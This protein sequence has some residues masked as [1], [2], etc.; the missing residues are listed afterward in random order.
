MGREG[1]GESVSKEVQEQPRKGSN[2]AAVTA[3]AGGDQPAGTADAPLPQAA[4]HLKDASGEAGGRADQGDGNGPSHEPSNERTESSPK[5]AGEASEPGERSEASPRDGEDE[6]KRDAVDGS[7]GQEGGS[8]EVSSDAVTL[9]T[10]SEEVSTKGA[11]EAA[12]KGVSNASPRSDAPPEREDADHLGSGGQGSTPNSAIEAKHA[13]NADESDSANVSSSN[14]SSS[15]R[16]DER[17]DANGHEEAETEGEG[18][19]LAEREDDEADAADE[20]EAKGADVT[21]EGN[22]FNENGEEEEG[23]VEEEG[24]EGGEDGEEGEGGE[25]GEEGEYGAE[26]QLEVLME[27]SARV[28]LENKLLRSE[29]RALNDEVT[30]LA[31]RMRQEHEALDKAADALHALELETLEKDRQLA[32]FRRNEDE[33]DMVLAQKDASHAALQVKLEEGTLSHLYLFFI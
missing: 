29:V 32:R 9:G 22:E 16:E 17:P 20:G 25:E 31:E 1:D 4:D 13:N 3:A 15:P 6:G 2:P 24:G 30:A 11:D 7:G 14:L 27:E 23:E 12:G 18:N 19:D 10:V 5:G 21:A 26:E 33:F 28:K 8:G